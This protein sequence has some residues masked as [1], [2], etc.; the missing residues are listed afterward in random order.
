[1]AIADIEDTPTQRPRKGP[2]CDV[3]NAL[4]TLPPSEAAALRRHLSNPEWRYSAL[5]ERVKN[6][7]DNPRDISPQT[8]ARHARGLC[9]AREKLR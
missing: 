8:Y 3:C 4:A 5:A 2:P 6:D 1:M 7:P 9:M